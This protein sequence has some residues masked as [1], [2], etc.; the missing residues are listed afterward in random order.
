MA[1][2]RDSRRLNQT[3][4]GCPPLVRLIP[5]LLCIQRSELK[6]KLLK[7][8]IAR[9]FSRSILI[10]LPSEWYITPLL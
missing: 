8:L 7:L 2:P 5:Y 9:L 3:F 4:R 6:C 10:L 1:E